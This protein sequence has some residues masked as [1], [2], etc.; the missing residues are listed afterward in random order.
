[1]IG[2]RVIFHNKNYHISSTYDEFVTLNYNM[3]AG[4]GLT[5]LDFNLSSVKYEFF[6]VSES[7]K[8]T[9]QLPNFGSNGSNTLSGSLSLFSAV[10]NL[11]FKA[12]PNFIS[13]GTDTSSYWLVI[14]DPGYS[15]DSIYV[16]YSITFPPK[17]PVYHY[18]FD[19]TI[20]LSDTTK[21]QNVM[22]NFSTSAQLNRDYCYKDSVVIENEFE[23]P[24]GWFV[25]GS[26]KFIKSFPISHSKTK[27]LVAL[28]GYSPIPER[29]ILNINTFHFNKINGVFKNIIRIYN[30]K[31]SANTVA[32]S[33]YILN[34]CILNKEEH[35]L[36]NDPAIP[37]CE[38]DTLFV[39]KDQ[40]KFKDIKVL[41]SILDSFLIVKDKTIVCTAKDQLNCAVVDSFTINLLRPHPEKLCLVTVDSA[42]NK[43]AI[44][45]DKTALKNTKLFRIYKQGSTFNQFDLLTERAYGEVNVY[46]D[47]LS[48]PEAYSD[49]YKV[50]AVD[51]CGY[52]SVLSSYHKTMHLSAS[53][54]INDRVELRWEPY[55][56]LGFP[57]VNIYRG[58]N[59]QNMQL[60]AARPGNTISYSDI[61]PPRGV[62]YYQ[63]EIIAPNVCEIK[64]SGDFVL[65]SKSN[66]DF[67]SATATDD[68]LKFKWDVTPT[69]QNHVYRI[70]IDESILGT[71]Y[72]MIDGMG[73]TLLK[74]KLDS[75]EVLLNLEQFSAGVYYVVVGASVKKIMRL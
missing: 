24:N 31:D 46:I 72:T 64:R 62:L 52:E 8:W 73:R 51:S 68:L 4:F 65:S 67:A 33:T 49:F 54:G 56:G 40:S 55:E 15:V 47:N 3:K 59:P 9:Q 28:P 32:V 57:T 1:M 53:Q 22:Y 29:R 27:M 35:I 10:I 21:W 37:F 70:T 71:Y 43:N 2:Q 17:Y 69:N 48:N 18:F 34:V 23:Y 42:T 50:T 45:Y 58:S 20:A 61:N 66:I 16:K 11:E 63:T 75:K 6:P 19:P 25:E 7:S 39:V 74:D 60:L 44:V 26:N 14:T 41:G 30:P 36:L 38:A 12:S 5:R 13:C